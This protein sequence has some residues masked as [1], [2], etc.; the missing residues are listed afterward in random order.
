MKRCIRK[1]GGVLEGEEVYSHC[2]ILRELQLICCF[3]QYAIPI[4]L[5]LFVDDDSL[6][7]HY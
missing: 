3:L 7:F 2:V 5:T 6:Y 4:H 1:G